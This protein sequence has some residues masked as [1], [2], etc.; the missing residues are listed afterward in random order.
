MLHLFR[1][2][3]LA[4]VAFSTTLLFNSFLNTALFLKFF[5]F[6]GWRGIHQNVLL[7]VTQYLSALSCEITNMAWNLPVQRLS[8]ALYPSISSCPTLPSLVADDP[9]LRA[10]PVEK[11]NIRRRWAE[12]LSPAT[13]TCSDG[14][15]PH[16][17]QAHYAELYKGKIA[18]G[19]MSMRPPPLCGSLQKK[20][21]AA[22]IPPSAFPNAAWSPTL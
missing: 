5:I 21:P 10:I 3:S 17:C 16:S 20:S 14:A 7:S 12:H 15:T 4:L 2:S 22:A 11:T 6:H 8:F 19:S 18:V 9:I 1:V 13:C